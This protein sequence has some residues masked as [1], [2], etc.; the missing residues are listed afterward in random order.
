MIKKQSLTEER[1]SPQRL[2]SIFVEREG[3]SA[4]LPVPHPSVK[5]AGRSASV[6]LPAALR[7][8]VPATG[9]W[10]LTG[11]GSA[12]SDEISAELH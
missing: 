3:Q 9:P 4:L 11:I 12:A 5:M 10:P 8:L 1:G 2:L 7:R 6:W